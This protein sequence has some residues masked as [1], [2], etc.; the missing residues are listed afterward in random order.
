MIKYF[1]E[2]TK[3]DYQAMIDK[4]GM[5]Y[6]DLARDYPG[7]KWCEYGEP[8]EGIMGCWSLMAHLVTGEWFCISCDC[9]HGHRIYAM[10]NDYYPDQQ[11]HK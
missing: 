5:T 8:T 6:A 7:P 3:E 10:A 9:H 11:L 2:L 4:G 1:H